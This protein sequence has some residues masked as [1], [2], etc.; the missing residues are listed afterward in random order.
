MEMAMS[1][2]LT[3]WKV[4]PIRN[5]MAEYRRAQGNYFL[6]GKPVIESK[7]GGKIYSLVTPPSGSRV[8]RRRVRLILDNLSVQQCTPDQ[9]R[10]LPMARTP[11]VVT[12]AV[13][14][15]CQCNC[16]HCSA[17]H[18]Q[19]E[20]RNQQNA[21]SFDELRGAIDQAVDLG[22][23]CVVL[24]GGEPLLYEKIFD[25][26]AAVD[27]SRSVC[28]IFTNGEYLTGTAVAQLKTAGVFGVYVSLDRPSAARHDENRGRP[29]LFEQAVQ[30]LERCQIAG[31]PTGISTYATKENLRNGE[32]DAMMNLAKSLRV[33]EVFIFDVIPTGRLSGRRECVLDESE[34]D[35]LREFRRKYS[36]R[37]DY[38]GIIHQSMFSSIA[39]PCVAE[40]CP[41][42]MVTAHVRANGDV[43][44]C[45]FT[46]HAFGNIRERSLKD[47]WKTMTAN[48][49][50]AKASAR[51]RLSQP[52]FWNKLDAL[53]S[54]KSSH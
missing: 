5:K 17:A 25:L 11:H 44:P 36:E 45:D 37:S 40:G 14:Y 13:T 52:A 50:Y 35:A 16:L 12:L 32:L 41:A 53:C 1:G 4:S 42:G 8:A 49:L 23:T 2:G 38:P 34:A 6:Q 47:I 30:G 24:T 3:T 29:G 27:K 19:E 46:P 31:I 43:C 54:V 20:V 22:S 26:I 7:S 48:D 9:T 15:N 21:L 28:T 51:C 10:N 39:Y 18:L 33:I